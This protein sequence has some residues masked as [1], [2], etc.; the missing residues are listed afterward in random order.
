MDQTES[1]H[2]EIGKSST[3]IDPAVA[4]ALA[5]L[6][7]FLSGL[8][9]LGIEKESRF[10]RFHAMQAVLLSAAAIA[11]SLALSILPWA[12]RAFLG[13][14]WMLAVLGVFIV[15]MWK[16]YQREWFGLPVVG[17]VARKQT[18]QWEPGK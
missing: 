4:A 7:G 6:F 12:F 8:L 10:V 5:Y 1:A 11:G 3:G 16:A 15:C 18:D 2:L 17:D 9:F 13:P 14:V